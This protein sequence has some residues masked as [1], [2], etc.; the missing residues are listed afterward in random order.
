MSLQLKLASFLLTL[1][2]RI[3]ARLEAYYATLAQESIYRPEIENNPARTRW[4]NVRRKIS[5]GS[6][7]ILAKPASLSDSADFTSDSQPRF[8]PNQANVDFAQIFASTQETLQSSPQAPALQTENESSEP[9]RLAEIHTARAAENAHAPSSFETQQ[10]EDA[11]KR[12]SAFINANMSSIRRLSRLPTSYDINDVMA[13]YDNAMARTTSTSRTAS[14][15][16]TTRSHHKAPS[17]ISN[18]SQQGL[19]SQTNTPPLPA[20]QALRFNTRTPTLESNIPLHYRQTPLPQ[21]QTQV[22]MVYRQAPQAPLPPIPQ[23][24]E[25]VPSQMYSMPPNAMVESPVSAFNAAVAHLTRRQPPRTGTPLP[26]NPRASLAM[27]ATARRQMSGDMPAV[28]SLPSM[29]AGLRDLKMAG[30]VNGDQIKFQQ[31]QARVS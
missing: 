13:A 16:L 9:K 23:H 17:S 1:L 25:M 29:V 27:S 15:A 24:T 22:E 11:L 5:D 8:G 3:A 20:P 2:E 10:Q 6:F 7:F 19:R 26:A 12:M 21:L 14:P 18:S 31:M 28:P 4:Q 30:S